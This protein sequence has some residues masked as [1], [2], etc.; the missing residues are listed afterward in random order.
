MEFV[1]FGMSIL[2]IRLFVERDG[3]GGHDDDDDDA[4]IALLPGYLPH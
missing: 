2:I 3:G 1:H 4:H